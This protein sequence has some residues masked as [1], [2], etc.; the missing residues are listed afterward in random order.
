[1]RV[2]SPFGSRN[3]YRS[4]TIWRR[5]LAFFPRKF[6]DFLSLLSYTVVFYIVRHANNDGR[7]SGSKG[8]EFVTDD[9]HSLAVV[10]QNPTATLSQLTEASQ[11]WAAVSAEWKEEHPLQEDVVEPNPDRTAEQWSEH[12]RREPEVGISI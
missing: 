1:M 7:P 4:F 2:I 8:R 12:H 10:L 9:N 5:I 3:Q 6:P 11:A